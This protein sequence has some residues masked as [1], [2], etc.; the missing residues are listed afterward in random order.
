MVEH[1]LRVSAVLIGVASLRVDD[2]ALLA[3]RM[4]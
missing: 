4:R 2:G 3:L 1:P